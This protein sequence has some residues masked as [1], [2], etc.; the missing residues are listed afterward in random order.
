LTIGQ[1]MSWFSK[2][3]PAKEREQRRFYLLPGM[4]GRAL[5]RKQQ[6]IL[7]WSLVAGL[8]VSAAVAGILYLLSKMSR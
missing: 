7:R 2:V 5:R 6:L 8:L 4:G 3:D 1:E